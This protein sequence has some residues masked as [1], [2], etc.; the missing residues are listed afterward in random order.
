MAITGVAKTE[1]TSLIKQIQKELMALKE[2]RYLWEDI[3][4]EE[5]EWIGHFPFLYFAKSKT[6]I[7][8]RYYTPSV[9]WSFKEEG[10]DGLPIGLI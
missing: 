7:A 1:R 6:I 2:P 10:T 8:G 4:N 3:R 9:K 5:N